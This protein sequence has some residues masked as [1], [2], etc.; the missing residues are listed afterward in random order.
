MRAS[1][2]I[3]NGK[4]QRRERRVRKKDNFDLFSNVF[5]RCNF[6]KWKNCI[7]ASFCFQKRVVILKTNWPQL[8]N[9]FRLNSVHIKITIIIINRSLSFFSSPFNILSASI[10]FLFFSFHVD[11]ISNKNEFKTIF[12]AKLIVAQL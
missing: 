2:K 7:P 6:Y 5:W 3:K 11:I 9:H 4:E 12:S 10:R 1:L 8:L